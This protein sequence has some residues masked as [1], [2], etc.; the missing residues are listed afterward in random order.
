[1]LKKELSVANRAAKAAGNILTQMIGQID[2]IKKKGEIDLVTEADLKAEESILEMIHAEFPR[3]N[4][5][6]EESGEHREVSD[7]TWIVDPLDGTTNF[8]HGF[9]FF[10]VSIALEIRG[11]IVLGIVYNPYM[12]EHFEGIK[13]AGA[14]LNKRPIHVSKIPTLKESLLATGFYYD[15]HENPDRTMRYFR[16]MV[17]R[18]QGLRRP[19]SAALDLCYVA[20]GMVDGFWEEG[21]KPWDT[22]AGMLMVQEAG[23]RLSTFSGAPYSPYQNTILA[24][25]SIIHEQ[26]LKVLNS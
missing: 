11:D 25:N 4:I 19:G 12:S 17:V 9:P 13:N 5:L 1:M 6:S 24:S 2:H 3:D 18:A 14:F 8:A 20:A 7:R 23:G 21:L 22:A 15:I 16:N 10:A 26:M